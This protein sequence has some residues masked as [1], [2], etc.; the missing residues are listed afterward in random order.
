MKTLQAISTIK[1][2][3]TDTVGFVQSNLKFLCVCE[4]VYLRDLKHDVR[5]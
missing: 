5:S 2:Q 3:V 4:A 1:K